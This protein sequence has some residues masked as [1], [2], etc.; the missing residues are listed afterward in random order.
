MDH[1]PQA[2]RF[3]TPIWL[4]NLRLAEFIARMSRLTRGC[5]VTY[6]FEKGFLSNPILGEQPQRKK[7]RWQRKSHTQSVRQNQ[8]LSLLGYSA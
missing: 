6:F 7:T 1:E 4:L 5:S 8:P 3:D 2:R